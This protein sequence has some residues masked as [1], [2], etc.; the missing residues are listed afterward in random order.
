MA[1]DLSPPHRVKAAVFGRAAFLG[2]MFVAMAAL[3]AWYLATELPREVTGLLRERDVWQRGQPAAEASY[4]GDVT[5][6][7]LIFRSYKLKVSYADASGAAHVGRLEFDTLGSTLDDEAPSEVRYDPQRPESFALGKA[8][9]VAAGR[10]A[11]AAFMG[12]MGV[13][14]VGLVGSALHALFRDLRRTLRCARDG[15]L[16]DVALVG[17]PSSDQHGNTTYRFRIPGAPEGE[18]PG[19]VVFGKQLG[20]LHRRG[21]ATAA[22]ALQSASDPGAVVVLRSDRYPFE[23]S[24][25]D[26]ERISIASRG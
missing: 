11:S 19:S 5:T 3:M 24:A 15:R 21:D 6:R 7:K 1:Y 25:A 9:D 20:P 12:G 4:E 10:W 8:L 14:I 18:K 23:F 16:I 22:L 26:E 13:V 2:P 17:E